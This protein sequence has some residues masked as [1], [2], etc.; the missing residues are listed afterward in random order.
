MAVRRIAHVCAKGGEGMPPSIAHAN[1]AIVVGPMVLTM[2]GFATLHH[3]LPCPVE[4]GSGL[5]VKLSAQAPTTLI[6]AAPKSGDAGESR[7]ATVA[8]ALPPELSAHPAVHL[9]D[10]QLPKTLP[11]HVDRLC[12][13]G[14]LLSP[15]LALNTLEVF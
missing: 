13:S 8:T 4:P 1:A 10:N 11:G 2:L 6:Q 5:S 3:V 15:K 9:D 7:A 12:H 14:S